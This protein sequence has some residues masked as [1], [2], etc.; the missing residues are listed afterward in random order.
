MSDD[1]F[2]MK[3][4]WIVQDREQKLWE[5][6]LNERLVCSNLEVD[7]TNSKILLLAAEALEVWEAGA[8]EILNNNKT[9]GE[10]K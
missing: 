10:T 5:L 4:K 8:G 9:E 1:I 3:E 7:I 2:V 6:Y